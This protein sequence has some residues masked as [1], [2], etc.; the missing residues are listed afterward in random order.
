MGSQPQKRVLITGASAGIGKVTALYLAR[1]GYQVAATSRQLSRLD[2][3]MAEASA[4]SLP[5]LAYEPDINESASVD[6]VVPRVLEDTGELDAL[7]NNAGYGLWGYLEDLTMEELRAQFETNVFGVLR[8][9][10]AVLPHM[11]TRRTGTIVNIGSVAGHIGMPAG[12]AYAAS[13]FA[14]R[15]LTKVMRMEVARFGVRVVL[16]EPGLFRTNFHQNQVTAKRAL[17]PQSPYYSK[18][19]QG[20]RD[21]V[22]AQRWAGDPLKVSRAIEKVIRAKRPAQQYQVGIDAKLGA[23]A[24]R[25]IPEGLLERF[26]KRLEAK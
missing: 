17:D 11:R 16:I 2:G 1:R 14:L 22:Q 6:K 5:I 8:M 7:V 9:S 19:H 4:A 20:N 13:K 15:S 25:L 23:L 24:A 21:F 10:Q 12:G 3:L 26:I 18:S